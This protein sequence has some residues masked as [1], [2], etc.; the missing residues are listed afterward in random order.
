MKRFAFIFIIFLVV[1]NT[2]C[3][4]DADRV[5][6]TDLS[7][8]ANQL[9]E[10]SSNWGESL[11]FA[12]FNFEDYRQMESEFFPGCP[13]I[14][15]SDGDRRVVLDFSNKKGCDSDDKTFR[16]GKIILE[17]SQKIGFQSFW[18]MR[19]E[20]YSYKGF[21]ITGVRNFT[22]INLSQ[23][24]ENF[25]NL[26]FQSE[27]GLNTVLSGDFSHNPIISNGLLSSLRTT[28]KMTG[29]NPAGRAISMQIQSIREEKLQCF[30]TEEPGLPNSSV[31]IWEISRTFPE[32]VSHTL[33]F[34][35]TDP[36]L[37]QVEALLSDGRR[38]QLK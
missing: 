36:C 29:K 37:V 1:L 25:E 15:V 9:L 14:L 32:T 16:S 26:T 19:Y 11:F 31:E 7:V 4:E 22:F 30:L 3:Q 18:T 35:S 34:E 5:I 24:R 20:D 8:E 23:I 13:E 2:S 27:K 10:T 21:K 6:R 17:F 38:L 33:Y 28:G 12:M